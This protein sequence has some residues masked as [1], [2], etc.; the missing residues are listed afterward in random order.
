MPSGSDMGTL[1][2]NTCGNMLFSNITQADS[3][4]E[5]VDELLPELIADDELEDIDLSEM[6]LSDGK[7]ICGIK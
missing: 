5:D 2:W 3:P 7:F 1:D 4:L 6:G